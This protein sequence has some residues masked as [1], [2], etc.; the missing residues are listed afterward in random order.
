MTTPLPMFSLLYQKRRR[1]PSV[2]AE[3]GGESMD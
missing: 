2:K 1:S 3:K